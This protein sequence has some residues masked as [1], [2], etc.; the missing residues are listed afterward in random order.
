M[1]ARVNHFHFHYVC[2]AVFFPVFNAKMFRKK[3]AEGGKN[4][5]KLRVLKPSYCKFRTW[6]FSFSFFLSFAAWKREPEIIICFRSLSTTEGQASCCRRRRRVPLQWILFSAKKIFLGTIQ[7]LPKGNQ[8]LSSFSRP[9]KF[10]SKW[11][12]TSGAPKKTLGSV[13]WNLPNVTNC[14]S[15]QPTNGEFLHP[16]ILQ[17]TLV[18]EAPLQIFYPTA[19]NQ[20]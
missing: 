5:K 9:K 19:A 20:L 14:L 8:L 11:S 10:V 4:I 17:S 2:P 6:C 3:P 1:E 12:I 18:S 15:F 13:R 7:S 16:S